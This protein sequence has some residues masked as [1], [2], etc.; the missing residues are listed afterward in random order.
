MA[1]EATVTGLAHWTA[2][3]CIIAVY[4]FTLITCQQAHLCRFA[5]LRSKVAAQT[6]L[7][8]CDGSAQLVSFHLA[9]GNLLLESQHLLTAV[10]CLSWQMQHVL[11]VILDMRHVDMSSAEIEW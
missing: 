3:F 2:V 5:L 9:T 6:H 11:C 4:R 1:V 8:E 7:I 10:G